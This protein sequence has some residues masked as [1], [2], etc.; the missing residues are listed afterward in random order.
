MRP[1]DFGLAVMVCTFFTRSTKGVSTVAV[2]YGL[3][4]LVLIMLIRLGLFARL[5]GRGQAESGG[6]CRGTLLPT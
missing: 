3:G 4:A 2:I 1:V 5:N 6:R